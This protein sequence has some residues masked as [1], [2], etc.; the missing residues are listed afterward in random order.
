M[1]VDGRSLLPTGVRRVKGIFAKGDPVGIASLDNN[2]FAQGLANLSSAELKRFKGQS[3]REIKEGIGRAIGSCVAV[4]RND[5][6]LMRETR[7]FK[8]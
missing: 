3:T 6:V 8:S 1:E 4:H 7:P 2:V 5:L